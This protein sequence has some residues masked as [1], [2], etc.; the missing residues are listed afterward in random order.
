MT[1]ADADARRRRK[2][3]QAQTYSKQ[4][5]VASA[6]SQSCLNLSR[7]SAGT[8]SSTA[9]NNAEADFDITI[10][11]GRTT[12][13]ALSAP[14][15]QR[16]NLLWFITHTPSVLLRSSRQNSGGTPRSAC[17]GKTGNKKFM[18]VLRYADYTCVPYAVY[19]TR[20]Y[21]RTSGA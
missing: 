4:R 1:G 5:Y 18:R 15:D 10:R 3:T 16:T 9:A 20:T 11:A 7:H 12:S 6:F 19:R 13:Q 14:A 17:Q 2:L 21:E 8:T